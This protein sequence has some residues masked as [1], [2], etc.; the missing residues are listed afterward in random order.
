[1]EGENELFNLEDLQKS[2]TEIGKQ[3]VALKKEITQQET[4]LALKEHILKARNHANQILENMES[5]MKL[6]IETISLESQT[7][8]HEFSKL[9]EQ[10]EAHL[11]ENEE[12]ELELQYL[13]IVDRK[14]DDLLKDAEGRHSKFQ[15]QHAL[16]VKNI[17]KDLG[18]ESQ[19]LDFEIMTKKEEKAQ[20][21]QELGK[22][23]SKQRKIQK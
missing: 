1:M 19:L 15:A 17:Q 18:Q 4:K 16:E 10:I 8:Q 3:N 12:V 11:I 21:E 7:C 13:E 22:I 9:Q 20:L 5:E 23:I 2:L 14:L 6:S